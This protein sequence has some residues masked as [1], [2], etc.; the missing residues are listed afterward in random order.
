MS[1]MREIKSPTLLP[2]KVNLLQQKKSFNFVNE[3]F[4]GRG[5]GR[6]DFAQGGSPEPNKIKEKAKILTK[7]IL[8]GN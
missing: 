6:D 2:P 3:S 8:K 7:M 1:V 5:G 4:N